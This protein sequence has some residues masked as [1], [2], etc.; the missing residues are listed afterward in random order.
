MITVNIFVPNPVEGGVPGSLTTT[1]SPR[2]VEQP[3]P[4]KQRPTDFGNQAL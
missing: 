3:S 2:R 4:G 1:Y